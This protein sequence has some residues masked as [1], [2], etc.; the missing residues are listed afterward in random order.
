MN[1]TKI[2]L[3][4]IQF[5]LLFTALLYTVCN[6]INFDRIAKWFLLG[7]T[8]DYAALFAYLVFGWCFLLA[9]FVLLAYRWTIK[10]LALLFI[11][12]SATATYFIAKYNVAVDRTMVI[13]SLHTDATEVGSLLS[14][15]MVPYALFLIV[16]PSSMVLSVK[17]RFQRTSKYLASSLCV[18]ILA[19]A[20]GAGLI[21]LEYPSIHRAGNV[22]NK[23]IINSLV[24]VNLIRSIASASYRS[25]APYW[26][27]TALPTEITGQITQQQDLVVVLAIGESARQKNFSLY[28]YTKNNTNPILSKDKSLHALNGRAKIGSTLL[29]LPEILEKGGIKLPA[30]THALGI[31]TA[32]YVNF[33]LYDN[34][35]AVGEVAVRDC[36]HNGRCYD[37]D[38]IPLLEENLNS[39]KNGQRLVVLHLGGGSH[40]PIYKD[41]HPPEFQ[42]F[43]PQ[44]LDA[45]VVNQCSIEQ[46]YNSYDNTIVY[47]D[48]VLGKAID[49]LGNYIHKSV[50]PVLLPALLKFKF[51]I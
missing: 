46:L 31:E 15:Q 42:V 48:Y 43:N 50:G 18:F 5:S 6:W 39:Y 33:K 11:V 47:T 16:L 30:I 14:V 32:C 12:L 7:D 19:L 51:L 49:K 29:A 3:S 41:R 34:C 8:I 25:L 10:P 38:V 22:S 45:D 44:C 23:A 28:G 26:Q 1:K 40:G 36:G 13:N 2:E 35:N 20:V 37:E 21:Y 4:H 9:F 17:I 27:R 24:P